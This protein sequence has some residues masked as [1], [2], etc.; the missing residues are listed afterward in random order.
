M[1]DLEQRLAGL[2][3]AAFQWA[4]HCTGGRREDAEDALQATYMALLDGSA[5][6]REES[7]FKSFVF[8]VIRNKARALHRKKKVRRL[9]S[10][11]DVDPPDVEAVGAAGMEAADRREAIRRAIQA[12]SSRQREV[13]ELVFYHDMTI[14]D[15]SAVMGVGL[16]TARTHYKRAKESMLKQ[17]SPGEKRWLKTTIGS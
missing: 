16:G 7:S 17:L 10:L 1:S 11:E 4:L 15:A 5:S 14:E 8:A 3:D 13:L 12:L 6:F 9:V 2:H